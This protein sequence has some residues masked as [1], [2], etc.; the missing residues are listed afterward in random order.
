MR[1]L[2]P[3]PRSGIALF[4]VLALAFSLIPVGAVAQAP[5]GDVAFT[6]VGGTV[7]VPEGQ[8]TDQISGMAG[9]IVIQGTV[10]GDVSGLA[11]DVV[12]AES[13]TVRGDVS[14]ATGSLRIAGTVGGNVAAAA[15]AVDV[16]ETGSVGGDFS[17]GAG[18]VDVAGRIDGNA[19]VGADQILLRPSAVIAGDLRYD[20]NLVR[21]SGSTVQGSIILDRNMGGVSP[22]S[23]ATPGVRIPSWFDVVYGF[24]A[25]LVLGVILLLIFPNFSRRVAENVVSQPVRAGAI[26]LLILLGIPIL[27]VFI[28]L[29]IIGIPIAV[30]GAFVY[31]LTIWAGV[32]YGEYAVGH[33]LLSRRSEEVNRW[34]ALLAGLLIFAVLGLIPFVGG[35]FAFLALL[36]GLGALGSSLRGAYRNRRG[37][38]PTDAD[39]PME[40]GGGGDTPPA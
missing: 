37:P 32:V 21:Q 4:L 36:V 11:G 33:W 10:T 18:N 38:R 26:G 25:N 16:E 15:G 29:T 1:P 20:G 8:T 24:F 40:S 23:W 19:A 31:G 22:V 2:R 34:Y 3:H 9:T 27:L 14:V 17:V 13:G 30:L 35:L 5:A 39:A 28:A 7:V 12:I 6:G